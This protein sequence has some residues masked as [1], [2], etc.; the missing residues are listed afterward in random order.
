LNPKHSV[1]KQYQ[2][3]AYYFV[4]VPVHFSKSAIRRNDFLK[5]QEVMGVDEAPAVAHPFKKYVETRWLARGQVCFSND[6]GLPY[7]LEE[8]IYNN[9]TSTGVVLLFYHH[10]NPPPK[11]K[12]IKIK[13]V[14]CY[15]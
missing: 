15:L 6:T 10:T 11:K 14:F 12:I 2:Y 8:N 3:L 9:G 7:I 5:I 4:Q 13:T 1:E